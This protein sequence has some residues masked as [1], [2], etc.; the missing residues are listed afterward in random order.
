MRGVPPPI[1]GGRGGCPGVRQMDVP[2]GSPVPA[3]P[4]GLWEA[5]QV[6]II[7][8]NPDVPAVHDNERE[9]T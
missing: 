5:G 6:N 1:R 7:E 8:P 9:E 2:G 3:L 4:G